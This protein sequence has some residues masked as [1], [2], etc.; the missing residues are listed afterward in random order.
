MLK[1]HV[2]GARLKLKVQRAEEEKS[3]GGIFLAPATTSVVDQR[4]GEVVEIGHT[5]YKGLLDETPWVKV[6]DTVLFPR[7]AGADI[8]EGNDFFRFIKDVDVIAVVEKTED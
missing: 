6:G 1:H 3:K 7:Y 4:Y 8:P 5:A 2:K